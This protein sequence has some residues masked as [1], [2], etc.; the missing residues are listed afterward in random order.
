MSS[1]FQLIFERHAWREYLEWL[2]DDLKTIKKIN[3]LI[4]SI[5]RDGYAD[6]LGLPERLKWEKNQYW[7][8]R[9]NKYDRFVYK[10]IE[11]GI[12]VISS[13]GHYE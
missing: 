13:K 8:R 10:V 11:N 5:E 3:N 1:E 7:S 12:V 6:G 2:H 9:I 4:Q